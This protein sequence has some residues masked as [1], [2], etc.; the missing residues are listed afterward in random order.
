MI[1]KHLRDGERYPWFA[2]VAIDTMSTFVLQSSSGFSPFELVFCLK[3]LD[4]LNLASPLF[5][6]LPKIHKR[7]LAISERKNRIC[8]IYKLDYKTQ[9]AQD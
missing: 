7:S 2:V 4:L 9:K 6:Q 8:S 5:E 3:P 1:T